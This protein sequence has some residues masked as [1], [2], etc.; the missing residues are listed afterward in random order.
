MDKSRNTGF[1]RYKTELVVFEIRL[2]EIEK[3]KKG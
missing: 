2:S 3:L 1:L